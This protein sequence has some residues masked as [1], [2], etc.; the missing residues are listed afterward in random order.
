M[1]YPNSIQNLINQFAK[2]PSIGPKSAER[3]VFYLLRQDKQ[4]LTDFGEAIEHIKE[5]VIICNNCL[6]FSESNP[7]AIC[8]DVRR[9]QKIICL[10]AKPQD[11]IALEKASTFGGV[12]FVLGESINPL[13]GMADNRR[14]QLLI[15]KIKNS[16]VT[17][18]IF[19][20]N[21]DLRGETATLYL[22]KLIRQYLPNVA[23]SRLARGLPMGADLEYADEITLENAL[24]S[25]QKI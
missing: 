14:L 8:G 5:K 22:T 4:K 1:N 23:L 13:E 17:E 12:Y 20:L 2:L 15:N 16:Q 6:N 7:C 25:R 21:P 11:V 24:N 9:D 18:V 19:G 3:L 10:V